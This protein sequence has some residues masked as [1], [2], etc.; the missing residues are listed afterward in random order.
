MATMVS[1]RRVVG[2]W[3]LALTAVAIAVFAPFPYLTAPLN[4]LGDSGLASHYATKPA[5][6]H[7]VLYVHMVGS[8]LALL[9]SPVQL[10]SRLR[11]RVPRLHR[12]VGRVTVVAMLVGGTAGGVLAP[13]SVAGV[14]G[15][16][17]FGLL[18]VLS[19]AFP[20]LGFVAIRRGDVAGHRQWM[21]RAFAMVY[22]G[23]MLRVGIAV[24]MPLTGD[25][26]S[27]YLLMPFGSWVPNLLLVEWVLWRERARG[28]VVV[29]PRTA[30]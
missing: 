22:A 28:R 27:A 13:M 20:V 5:W 3:W 2:F 4:D 26:M 24:L 9:L 23:V 15:A 21:L 18:A 12:V 17:G 29:A 10:S 7:V 25:F 16:F 6:V 1:A 14:V 8:G 19:V 11:A 30:V